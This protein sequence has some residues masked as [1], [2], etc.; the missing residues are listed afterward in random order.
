MRQEDD[1]SCVSREVGTRL[2]RLRPGV[3]LT[4]SDLARRF[5]VPRPRGEPSAPT[6]LALDGPDRFFH[7]K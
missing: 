1:R 2:R 4:Q 6:Q 3:R 7:R 5:A